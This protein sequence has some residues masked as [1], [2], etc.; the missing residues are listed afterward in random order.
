[1]RTASLEAGIENH[2]STLASI[3]TQLH[4]SFRYA[5]PEKVAARRERRQ[6]SSWGRGCSRHRQS[7]PCRSEDCL[8]RCY[9]RADGEC[10]LTLVE[11]SSV[12]LD[13]HTEVPA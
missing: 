6:H 5:I 3:R 2:S 1:M 12:K 11:S 9:Q 13:F 10:P 7:Q 8:N 4:G